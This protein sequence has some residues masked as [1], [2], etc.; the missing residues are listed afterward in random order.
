[1]SSDCP[2]KVC[3][4]H[5]FSPVAREAHMARYPE[6][7]NVKLPQ[8]AVQVDAQPQVY[9]SKRKRQKAELEESV[10]AK[11]TEKSL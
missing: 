5:F 7:F 1:M 3:N 2:N 10:E 6:H 4:M 8:R 11:Q 9:Q